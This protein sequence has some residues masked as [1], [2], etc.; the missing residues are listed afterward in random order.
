[1]F[2]SSLLITCVFYLF[3]LLWYT[4]QDL[5]YNLNRSDYS[6]YPWLITNAR[7]EAFNISPVG[8]IFA[9]NVVCVYSVSQSCLTLCNPTDYRPPDSSV[10]GVFQARILGQV[11]TSYSRDLPDLGMEPMSLVSPILAGRFFTTVPLGKP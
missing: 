4:S 1:M 10:H 9:I 2:I 8:M 3:P 5:Q 7:G 11:A 6:G